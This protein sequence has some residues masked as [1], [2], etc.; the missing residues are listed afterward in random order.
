MEFVKEMT[1]MGL[2]EILQQSEEHTDSIEDVIKRSAVLKKFNPNPLPEDSINLFDKN[3]VSFYKEN[4]VVKDALTLIK[5]RRLDTAVN[6]PKTLWVS[7]TDYTHKNRVVFPFYSNDGNKVDTYQ[8]RALYDKDAEIAKY[9]TK[10]NSEKGIF[11]I[12]K[13]SADSDYIFFQEGPID[14]M[15]LRNCVAL[16]GIHPTEHQLDRINSQFP[17][18]NQV[19]VLDN[20]WLD[21]T[22][23]KI[24]KDLLDKG[25]TVFIWPEYLSEYKDLNELCI[26]QQKDEVEIDFILKNTY[27][28][29]KGLLQFSQICKPS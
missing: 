16:A 24:T 21:K 10:S 12:D 17:L 15:F 13:V 14:A 1:G 22:S 27:T 29:V 18:H 26:A 11:N 6:R 2:N 5:T 28:G 4:I 23:H 20:Q 19:Y 7:L 9:L 3:Q 25:K 8:S